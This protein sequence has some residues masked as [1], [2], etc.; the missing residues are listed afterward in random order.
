MMDITAGGGTEAVSG[1]HGDDISCCLSDE[2]ILH[3]A[4]LGIKVLFVII[5]PH[6]PHAVHRCGLLL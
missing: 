5:R 3:L 2:V 6:F 4:K 1:S